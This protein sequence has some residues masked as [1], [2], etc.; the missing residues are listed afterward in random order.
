MSNNKTGWKKWVERGVDEWRFFLLFL[1][2]F[3]PFCF[4]TDWKISYS[5][6]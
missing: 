4:C 3:F 5:V 1:F 2:C 6:D